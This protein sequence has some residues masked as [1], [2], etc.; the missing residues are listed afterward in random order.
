L[1]L[2]LAAVFSIWYGFWARSNLRDGAERALGIGLLLVIAAVVAGAAGFGWRSPALDNFNPPGEGQPLRVGFQVSPTP[3]MLAGYE[4]APAHPDPGDIPSY[5]FALQEAKATLPVFPIPTPTFIPTASSDG[6]TPDT[7]PVVRLVI[8]ALSVDAEVKYVPFDEETWLISGLKQEIAWLGN[9]SWPG[10]GG[11]TALAGHVTVRGIG[12]GPFR[13]LDQLKTG[14]TLKVYTERAIYTYRVRE[15]IVVGE[16]DL[17]I[18]ES[19]ATSQ[20]TLITCTDWNKDFQTYLKRL[21][22]FAD[23]EGSTPITTRGSR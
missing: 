13:Y 4:I 23:L 20:L 15:Q 22:V 8:P 1:A 9:S 12:N 14:D 16:N 21:V 10:L 19:T 7:S 5:T 3:E 2:G 11:N 18:V 6:E 17:W